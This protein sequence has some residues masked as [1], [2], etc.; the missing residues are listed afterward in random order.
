MEVILGGKENAVKKYVIKLSGVARAATGGICVGRIQF[1]DCHRVERGKRIAA[2]LV[3]SEE[4]SVVALIQIRLFVRP[5]ASG[6]TVSND[7]ARLAAT[8]LTQLPN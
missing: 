4:G 5:H 2:R 7:S 8:H 1:S 3:G 6:L